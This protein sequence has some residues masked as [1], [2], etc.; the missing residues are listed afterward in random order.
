MSALGRNSPSA[1]CHRSA[2]VITVVGG[3]KV[4]T[5]V[6]SK[7]LRLKTDVRLLL[8]RMIASDSSFKNSCEVVSSLRN[9]LLGVLIHN[10]NRGRTNCFMDNSRRTRFDQLQVVG[11]RPLGCGRGCKVSE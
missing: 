2:R 6:S 5:C 8:A 4:R 9:I 3:L 7:G 11:V 10:L 1:G